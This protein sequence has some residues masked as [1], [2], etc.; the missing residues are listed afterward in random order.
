[1]ESIQLDPIVSMDDILLLEIS[2]QPDRDVVKCVDLPIS[3][4]LFVENVINL[5]HQHKH[6]YYR[7]TP[8][9][10]GVRHWMKTTVA[11]LFSVGYVVDESKVQEAKMALEKVWDSQDQRVA[12]EEQ[13]QMEIGTFFDPDKANTNL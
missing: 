3:E 2:R 11:L 12:S 10:R 13:S 9:G 6:D 1:M 8:E 7:F 5:L 4:G